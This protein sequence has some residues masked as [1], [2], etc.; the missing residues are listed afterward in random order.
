MATATVQ[1]GGNRSCYSYVVDTVLFLLSECWAFG[2]IVPARLR[3]RAGH[4][5]S[6]GVL[7]LRRYQK[8]GDDSVET[9][10]AHING[11]FCR[12]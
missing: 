3:V 10:P 12:S 5:S 8:F 9:P 1:I 4:A 7:L 6:V 2:I 11:S